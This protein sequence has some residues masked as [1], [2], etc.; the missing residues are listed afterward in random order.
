MNIHKKHNEIIGV[1]HKLTGFSIF[2]GPSSMYYSICNGECSYLV[3]G[4]IFNGDLSL[5]MCQFLGL[6]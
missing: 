5:S 4:F 6:W 1:K 3:K 2:H